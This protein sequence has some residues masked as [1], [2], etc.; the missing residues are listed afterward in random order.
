MRFR[1]TALPTRRETVIPS[2]APPVSRAYSSS[3]NERV[4]T[5]RPCAWIRKNSGRFRT[6]AA[7]GKEPAAGVTAGRDGAPATVAEGA[8]WTIDFPDRGDEDPGEGG[9]ARRY[10]ELLRQAVER[11]RRH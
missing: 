10:G 11:R 9:T 1:T 2:R 5:R 4:G 3:T 7:R 6:R 8:Y